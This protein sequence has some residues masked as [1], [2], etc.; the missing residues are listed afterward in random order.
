LS[1]VV[2]DGGRASAVI[3]RIRGFLKKERPDTVPVDMNE[4]IQEAVALSRAE[5]LRRQVDL[6]LDLFGALPPVTG[7]RIQLQQVILNLILNGSEAMVSAEGAKEL[8]LTSQQF[9]TG[10]VLIAVRDS[11]VGINPQDLDRMFDAFFTT[12]PNGMG[13]GLAISRSII[14]AHGGRIWAV[15]NDGPGLTV[16]FS[17]P[18]ADQES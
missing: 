5:L 12:K 7:D 17:L 10:G 11:G 14:E 9:D 1:L 4:T 18:V 15:S 8:L 13:M 16:Q 3:Q 2:R 6:R